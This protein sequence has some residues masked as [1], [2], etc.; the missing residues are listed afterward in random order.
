M[1]RRNKNREVPPGKPSNWHLGPVTQLRDLDLPGWARVHVTCHGRG[2]HAETPRQFGWVDIDPGGNPD[3][4]NLRPSRTFV[5][6]DPETGVPT[7]SSPRRMVVFRCR[8]CGVD[9]VIAS[10]DLGRIA[11]MLAAEKIA[12]IDV[13]SANTYRHLLA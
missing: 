3:Q 4:S 6:V 5:R 9:E 1:S 13:S 2:R 8:H 10:A 11:V 7:G 12:H